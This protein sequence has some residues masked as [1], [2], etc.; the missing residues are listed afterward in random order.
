[1][2]EIEPFEYGELRKDVLYMLHEDSANILIYIRNSEVPVT[3]KMLLIKTALPV[4]TLHL[5]LRQLKKGGFLSR[6]KKGLRTYYALT[7]KAT[8]YLD[9]FGEI[10]I[11]EIRPI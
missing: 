1:M 6:T 8:F 7:T 9:K 3:P 2:K 11:E 4:Q 5:K 10:I